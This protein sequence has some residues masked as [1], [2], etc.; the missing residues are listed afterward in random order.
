M[1]ALLPEGPMIRK[2]SRLHSWFGA[3]VTNHENQQLGFTSCLLLL[4]GRLNGLWTEREPAAAFPVKTD[5]AFHLAQ[6]N[7][8]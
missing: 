3:G 2:R 1:L 5:A 4:S 7:T 6:H 8:S